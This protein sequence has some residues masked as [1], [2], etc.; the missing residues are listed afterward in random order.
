MNRREAIYNFVVL[1][2]GAAILPSCV[3]DTA[4]GTI[5]FKNFSLGADEG[6]MMTQLVDAILP[7]TNF[8]GAADL[9]S[10][11][12]TLMMVDECNP[13]EKQQAFTD[14]MKAFDKFSR[15][16]FGASFTALPAAKK[17]ELLTA[18]EAKTGVPGKALDFYQTTRHYTL[19]SFTSSKEYLTD[20]VNY[21]MVPGS[22]F[23][24]CVPVNQA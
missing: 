19:K 21:K 20:I 17:N 5:A 4:K 8:I 9:K 12:F 6:R 16:K 10:D 24:G 18:M 7:K 3:G 11:E 2:A 23:K 1:S 14:G 15:D 13:P 22:N